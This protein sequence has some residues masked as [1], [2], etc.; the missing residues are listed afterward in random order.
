MQPK[1]NRLPQPRRTTVIVYLLLLMLCIGMVLGLRNCSPRGVLVDRPLQGGSVGDTIDVAML[2]SP[3]N[4]YI[5]DD[6]LGGYS[7][8]LLREIARRESQPVNFVPVTSTADAM[9]LLRQGKVDVIASLPV[10]ASA[11]ENVLFTDSV[12]T[13]RLV[14]IF[15]LPKDAQ[16]YTSPFELARRNVHIDSETAAMLRLQNLQKEIGDT[17]YIS[18]HD[19]LSGELIAMKVAAGEFGFGVINDKVAKDMQKKLPQLRT[20]PLGFTQLQSWGVADSTMLRRVNTLL[21][22][23]EAYPTTSTLRRRYNL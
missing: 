9:I 7:Y 2:Y 4:Y 10:N 17:I 18:R 23:A 11:G 5:Y 20:M 13:D 3:L 19:D 22:K 14:A 15:T 8:D 21:R 16:P 1:R 6:T 12:Y